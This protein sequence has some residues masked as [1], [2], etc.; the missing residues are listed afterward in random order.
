MQRQNIRE[1]YGLKGSCLAD[2]ALSCCCWCCT[3][4]QS[5]K[6]AKHR[7]D[8][9]RNSAGMEQGYRANAGMQYPGQ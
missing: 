4:V 7:E 2:L 6:E 3:L 9:A 5:D 8:V 1:K